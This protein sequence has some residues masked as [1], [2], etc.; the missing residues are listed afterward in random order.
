MKI[1]IFYIGFAVLMALCVLLLAR[2]SFVEVPLIFVSPSATRN[3]DAAALQE[4]AAGRRTLIVLKGWERAIEKAGITAADKVIADDLIELRNFFSDRPDALAL[5]PWYYADS[6]W[7]TLRLNGW[8]FWDSE[9]PFSVR[10][11]GWLPRFKRTEIS[12]IAAGGRVFLTRGVGNV[13]DRTD[14]IHYPWQGVAGLL[15][16]ADLTIVQLQSPLVYNYARPR[17][18]NLR[19]GRARYAGGFA[20]VDAVVLNGTPLADAGAA[21][22]A[23][24]LDVLAR[25]RIQT[26]GLA[27]DQNSVY[28]PRFLQA[29]K[30]KIALIAVNTTAPAQYTETDL[31][32]NTV[33]YHTAVWNKDRLEQA[34]VKA[35]AADFVLVVSETPLNWPDTPDNVIFINGLGSLISE[36][37]Q[38]G[39]I[40]RYFFYGRQLV[41]VD[42]LPVFL[43][44]QWYTEIKW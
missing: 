29:G 22:M 19:Y 44:E 39:F 28:E 10:R 38:P 17:N 26:V 34:M 6:R 25:M 1:K 32:G 35:A 9:Y 30:L 40:Q 15:S 33:L 37:A 8:Y 13:I 21:G 42:A 16:A 2:I 23:D 4:L 5:I 20:F 41:A 36:T 7:C 24:T 12:S 31:R 43:N 14:D 18:N 3:L 11:F 27:Q